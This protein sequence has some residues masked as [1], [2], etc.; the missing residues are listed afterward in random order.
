MK[1]TGLSEAYL[2]TMIHPEEKIIF[3]REE[4]MEEFLM[5]LRDFIP[6]KANSLVYC[7]LPDRLEMILFSELALH[8]IDICRTFQQV[9]LTYLELFS[10]H[11]DY[12]QLIEEC[13]WIIKALDEDGD[14]EENVTRLSRLPIELHLRKEG[15]PWNFAS[16]TLPG[17]RISVQEES[18]GLM[19]FVDTVLQEVSRSQRVSFSNLAWSGGRYKH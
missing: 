8:P 14:I 7:L 1:I 15:E 16:F 5:V 12:P 2:I 9:T 11:T 18:E 10:A 19:D 13:G 17:Q 6:E 3:W 4:Q